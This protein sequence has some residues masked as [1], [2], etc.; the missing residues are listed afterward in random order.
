[1]ACVRRSLPRPLRLA[2]L[3]AVIWLPFGFAVLMHSVPMAEP[4]AFLAWGVPEVLAGVRSQVVL[5]PFS[6]FLAIVLLGSI[7]EWLLVAVMAF[8]GLAAIAV[9]RRSL[10]QARRLA[11]GCCLGCGHQLL[12]GRNACP[13][14]GA[15]RPRPASTSTAPP[16]GSTRHRLVARG[17]SVV[18]TVAATAAGVVASM[19]VLAVA[20]QVRMQVHAERFMDLVRTAEAAGTSAGPYRVPWT[21]PTDIGLHDELVWGWSPDRGFSAHQG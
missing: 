10:R 11:A 15:I 1:M 8:V 4:Q 14:C 7:S 13:E 6:W 5:L 21:A 9:A 16:P 3:A 18:G 12:A 17:R 19:L 2:I 20:H